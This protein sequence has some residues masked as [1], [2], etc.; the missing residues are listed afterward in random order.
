MN[1]G[2]EIKE[3]VAKL[4]MEHGQFKFTSDDEI[5]RENERILIE[6]RGKV[7]KGK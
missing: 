6:Y 4:E 1:V 3:I 5:K 7:A 2:A